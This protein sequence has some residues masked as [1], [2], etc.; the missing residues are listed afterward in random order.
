MSQEGLIGYLVAAKVEVMGNQ[1]GT[2]AMTVFVR[3]L[4]ASVLSTCLLVAMPL[5][6]EE[7]MPVVVELFTSQGCSSCPPADEL[8]HELADRED[9]IALALHVDYWDYIGWEDKFAD[10]A[11]TER[12]R[13]YAIVAGRKSIYTPQMI[14][15][16]QDSIVG[17]KAMHLADAIQAHKGK[18]GGV[19]LQLSRDGDVVT[20]K[21]H[22]R[23]GHDKMVV[24][25]LRYLRDREV[26]ITRGENAG[27]QMRYANI[28]QGWQVLGK[29]SGDEDLL[30][31][32]PVTGDEPVVVLIQEEKQ[33]PILAAARI[34]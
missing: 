10:P 6:A 11:H 31:Q 28:V 16:G 19:S 33:G 5:S 30:L 9:V 27:R 23:K 29:W 17:A 7:T 8:M 13:A 2:Q 4:A 34:K 12:Q 18:D 14:V 3:R 21:A 24:H 26:N 22:D 32:A 25:M 15:N 1:G 20:V